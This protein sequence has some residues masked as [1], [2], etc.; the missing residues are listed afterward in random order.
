MAEKNAI[1]RKHAKLLI[2][3]K[4]DMDEIRSWPESA[5]KAA[6]VALNPS[7][8]NRICPWCILS[9]DCYE[10]TYAQRHGQCTENALINS[11]SRYGRIYFRLG[12]AGVVSLDGMRELVDKYKSIIAKKLA[13]EIKLELDGAGGN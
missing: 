4:P 7:W 5:C 9:K 6:L 11:T 1:V 12:R 8:D 3:T 10:C 2:A 13:K